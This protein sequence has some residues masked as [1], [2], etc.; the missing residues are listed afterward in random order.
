MTPETLADDEREREAIIAESGDVP[1]GRARAIARCEAQWRLGAQC[2]C[3]AHADAG[4][5]R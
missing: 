4:G 3:A 5:R 1:P 2:V